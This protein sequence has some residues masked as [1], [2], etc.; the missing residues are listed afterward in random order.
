MLCRRRG[1]WSRPWRST[2]AK[3]LLCRF[4]SSFGGSLLGRKGLEVLAHQLGVIEIKRARV[5]LLLRDADFR[6]I[7]DQDLGLDLQLPG[8]LINPD[9]VRI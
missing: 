5:R 6:Q 8:Q 4:L 1:G 7:L 2:W 3:A 9:L